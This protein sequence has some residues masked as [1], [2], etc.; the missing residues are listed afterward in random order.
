VHSFC[1]LL[2]LKFEIVLELS[3]TSN[4]EMFMLILR[5]ISTLL[6]NIIFSSS[7]LAS[8]W[9]IGHPGDACFTSVS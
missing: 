3:H 4:L 1:E 2:M 7:Y 6:L 9:S 5:L 8:T